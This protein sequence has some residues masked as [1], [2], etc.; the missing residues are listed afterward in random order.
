MRRVTDL[1]PQIFAP[2]A[3]FG[4]VGKQAG[5]GIFLAE[6]SQDIVELIVGQPV[7]LGADQQE[8]APG[9]VQEVQE[10][11]IALL[12]RNVDVDQGYAEGEGGTL[13]R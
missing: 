8:I 12:R 6:G 3:R 13:C 4:R 7:A 5:R 10:L 1:F 2:S 9:G 11:A